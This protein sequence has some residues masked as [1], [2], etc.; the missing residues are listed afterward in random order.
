MKRTYRPAA[1]V[2][3]GLTVLGA[4][5]DDGSSVATESTAT[6]AARSDGT[7]GTDDSAGDST[8]W[9]A[10]GVGSIY[11]THTAGPSGTVELVEFTPGP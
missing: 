10:R 6:S 11:T 4:C 8:V 7:V 5:G 9:Y 3:A 1:L 2:A